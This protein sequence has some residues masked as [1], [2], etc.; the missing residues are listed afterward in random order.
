MT[1]HRRM[2]VVDRLRGLAAAAMILGHSF[3]VYPVNI[4]QVP[5]CS[6]I[7]HFIYT[8]HMELFFVLAGVVYHCTDY[9]G[10]LRKKAERILLPYVFFG[11]A[12]VVLKAYGGRAVN[13][14]ES[15]EAGMLRLLL[16][17]GNYWFLYVLF[18]LFFLFPWIEKLCKSRK[19]ELLLGAGLLL[20]QEV[21]QLPDL[22]MVAYCVYYLPYFIAGRWLG[23]GWERTWEEKE[24]GKKGRIARIGADILLYVLIELVR[25]FGELEP[26]A[27]LKF[28]RGMA[29]IGVL[30][31]LL[32]WLPLTS[33]VRRILTDC[34]K[35]SLQ[36]YL[37]NGYLLTIFRVIICQ[38]L[39]IRS[40]F[41]IVMGIWIGNL[42]ITLLVCN[43]L[44][45]YI[46]LLRECCGIR[47]EGGHKD[48]KKR[49]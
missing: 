22:L 8:F 25:I 18:L 7:Q 30:Y 34:G 27:V 23:I 41:I 10:F 14:S 43:Y 42:V 45:P 11:V 26:G 49:G 47:R 2:E 19:K 3:I 20:L 39:R 6:A 33:A 40:P 16:Y 28:I 29:V 12:A 35:F 17:G 38:L 13:E 4:A 5:W 31:E 9:P 32:Q 1:V 36:L 37:F 24:A 48:D 15:I 21:I 46:P 44:L